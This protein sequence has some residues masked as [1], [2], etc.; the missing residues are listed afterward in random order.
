MRLQVERMAAS[1]MWGK[2]HSSSIARGHSDSGVASFSRS[3][4][5]AL[6]IVR[7]IEMMLRFFWFAYSVRKGGGWGGAGG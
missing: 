1:S 7:P 5:G 4:T 6:W 3:S 2:A